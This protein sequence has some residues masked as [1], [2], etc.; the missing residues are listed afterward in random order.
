MRLIKTIFLTILIISFIALLLYATIHSIIFA[1]VI[2]VLIWS[3]LTI[4]IA[5][6]IYSEIK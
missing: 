1:K 3:G 5:K 4:G 6:V 2:C